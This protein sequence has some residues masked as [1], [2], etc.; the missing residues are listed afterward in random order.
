MCN[1]DCLCCYYRGQNRENRFL[2]EIK[3]DLKAHEGTDSVEVLGGEPAIRTDFL[4]I[5]D[6]ARQQKYSRIKLR[7][8]GRAFA[9]W[10]IARAALEFGAWLFEIKLYGYSAEIHDTIAQQEGSFNETIQG[11]GNLKS[12]SIPAG[13]Q[14][15]DPF[16]AVRIPICKENYEYIEDTVRFV[17]PLRAD[18]IILSFVD[19]RIAVSDALSHIANAIETAIFS[20]VWI[21]TERIPLCLM[22]DYEH[23]VSEAFINNIDYLAEQ[24]ASCTK[25]VYASSC[26]GIALQYIDSVGTDEFTPVA[27]SSH[28]AD[29]E[30][31]KKASESESDKVRK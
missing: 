27:K 22:S 13:D 20:R 7:T 14:P 25:C 31:L 10:D 21:Q 8:N 12:L 4:D 2:S 9:D 26:Q 19:S 11:I 15:K 3:S 16:V 29:I 5:I 18:R 17:I 23:H 1:N 30:A 6:F 28:A 24:V